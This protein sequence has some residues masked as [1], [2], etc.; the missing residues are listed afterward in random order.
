MEERKWLKNLYELD[1]YV[2]PCSQ[3]NGLS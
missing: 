2:K 1:D 3:R